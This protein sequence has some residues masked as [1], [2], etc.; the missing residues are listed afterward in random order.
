[1]ATY[2]IDTAGI[3]G[4]G[5]TGA[6]SDPWATLAYAC[7][8]VTTPGDTIHVNA[9]TY[10]ETAQSVL[11]IGINIEGEGITSI[12]RSV[13]A[14]N[15]LIDMSSGSEGTNGNQTISYIYFDGEL[16]CR[17]AIII[18]ARSNVRIHHCT[19][20]DFL[21]WGV[22]YNGRTSY[23]TSAPTIYGT[24]NKFYDNQVH[25]CSVYSGYGEGA[26]KFGG[27]DGMLI[28]NNTMTQTGRAIGTN[29][30]VI[31]YYIEGFN[32]GCKIYNNTIT[33][34]EYDNITW[35]FAIELWQCEGGI[36]IYDN[37]IIGAIDIVIAEKGSYG[38]SVKIHDNLLGPVSVATHYEHGMHLERRISDAYVY[39][40]R[41]RN[42]DNPI[43]FSGFTASETFSNNW[44]YCNLLEEGYYGIE[45]QADYEDITYSYFYVLN[46][47]ILSSGGAWGVHVPEAQ[48][49]HFYIRNNIIQGFTGLLYSTCVR[50]SAGGG[51]VNDNIH[52]NNNVLYGNDNSNDPYPNT[53]LTNSTFT[54]NL[55]VDPIFVSGIDF[56]LAAGSPAIATGIN[57]GLTLDYDGDL[58]FNPPSIGAF[59]FGSAPPITGTPITSPPITNQLRIGAIKIL[60]SNCTIGI[61][62]RWWFNGW[63]YFNFQNGYEITQTSES[64]GTQV[65]RMFSVISKI[66]RPT[67]HKI[68]YAYQITLEGITPG[69]IGG[70][71][72]LLMAERVEQYEGGIWREV[73]IT[74]GEHLIRDAG[75]NSFILNFEISR[76]ELAIYST[77]Y[78]KSLRLYLGDI[79]C[80]MDDDEVVPLNKQ[81]NDIAE[82]Q[83][84]QSDFTA[85]FKIRK[86]RAMRALFELSGEV[87]ANTSFPYENQTC[88]LIQDNIEVITGGKLIL[89]K[90]DDQYYYVSI[91][92]GNLNFFKEIETL[93][94]TD[95]LLPTTNHTWNVATQAATHVGDPDYVYPLCEPS[96]DG[97]IAPLTDDGTRVE[98]YG[99]WIWPFI[100]VK[101]IWDEIFTNAGFICKGD[102]L[103]NETFLKLFMP[104]VNLKI[105][106]I[107]TSAFLYQGFWQGWRSFLSPIN[108]M[109]PMIPTTGT[110]YFGWTGIYITPY[111]ATYK[112]R[113]A[114]KVI[115]S[116]PTHVYLYSGAA[117]V[118]EL[119]QNP[120]YTWPYIWDGE[121]AAVAGENLTIRT[122]PF[123]N[124]IEFIV[125]VMEI[126]D[127]KI[128][129]SAAVT[130]HLN[131]PEL[132]QIDFI[133]TICNMFGLIPDV[134]PRDRI[135]RFWNYSELYDNIPIARDWS[136]Y[137]SER[138][139]ETEFK[140]GDYAQDNYLR[141]KE[142]D[143]VIKDTGMSSMQIDD[144]TLPAKKDT[145]EL[146]VSTCDE[147][148]ILTTNFRVDVSRIEFNKWNDDTGLY[149]QN[150]TIDPRIVYI[151]FVKEIASPPYQKEFWL[152]PT[153]LPLAGLF[154]P[155]SL[156]VITPKKASS[157]EVSFSNLVY[158]YAS[159]SRLLTKTNLRRA[160]F[161]LPVYEVAGLKHYIPIY[162]SQYKA[163][164]Y[165]NKINNY[166]P[167]QLCTIDLIKL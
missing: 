23:V 50:I 22:T 147:V 42:L 68:D 135:I 52:I 91:L 157:L 13:T 104:I 132:S 74:R 165:V 158:N 163:Y 136:K 9:G 86:T 76:K 32:K 151:N 83:D 64:L 47:V 162:L 93:K 95:L 66:E 107:D 119:N 92:S 126:T 90:V 87:G 38:F 134:T 24:G 56:H 43:Y 109:Y 61:Y 146:P 167:G 60:I 121:Y 141:Y 69:N 12:I 115:T 19:F 84:R 58:W 41:F 97:D 70:F 156:Q 82:M 5:H 62:L 51:V 150:E 36:E 105:A 164:F 127:I 4:A 48:T 40:N 67:R 110:S 99:G 28:Y 108:I 140:Y 143:D 81:T 1:M 138:E 124:C 55:K 45:I 153:E 77:V 73:D 148:K 114:C 10:T 128:G 155:P 17:G 103:T 149:D 125:A 49:D 130:P 31:K 46:N 144:E 79:L 21:E 27:Q 137:L 98:M 142:S 78:Q 112:F 133:K 94:L 161:N 154:A 72:G 152:R 37:T 89:D 63:H 3:D 113:F 33:K 116:Y 85:Q 100:K 111:V 53:G 16:T 65:S 44:I 57:V 122:T 7:T 117:M 26:L 6:I 18:Q 102:I 39:N 54:N 35:D 29:G 120:D 15:P 106:N 34:E 8:R 88:R 131:L 25:N 96:E 11:A 14:L 80:D 160:K 71:T 118:I 159:L 20:I 123:I 139:D 2:Y 75:E 166:V 30:Y 101:A 129:Y 145:V 59:E